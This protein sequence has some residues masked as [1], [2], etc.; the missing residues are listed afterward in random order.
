VWT[1]DELQLLLLDPGVLGGLEL[2][3]VLAEV[4]LELNAVLKWCPATGPEL[5]LEPVVDLQ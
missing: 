2:E 3:A 4:E 5:A 1:P